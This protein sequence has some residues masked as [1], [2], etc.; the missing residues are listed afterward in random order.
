[1]A[2]AFC[3]LIAKAQVINFDRL[4]STL[5]S[6]KAINWTSSTFG[7]GFGHRWISGDPGEFTTIDPKYRHNSSSRY[8]VLVISTLDNIDV[9][10][11]NLSK[12]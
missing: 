12:I 6:G 2:L 8:E 4:I 1:M 11:N 10:P 5:W 3:S 7:N 9:D